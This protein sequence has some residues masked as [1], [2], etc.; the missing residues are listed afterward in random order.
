MKNSTANDYGHPQDVKNVDER[1]QCGNKLAELGPQTVEIKCRRC[2]RIHFIPLGYLGDGLGESDETMDDLGDERCECGNLMCKTGLTVL[3]FKCRR[4][5]D[6]HYI[7][8]S[9]LP[10]EKFSNHDYE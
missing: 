6:L 10:P 3:E 1:C 7:R 8:I 9:D 4:C 2:K 5:K